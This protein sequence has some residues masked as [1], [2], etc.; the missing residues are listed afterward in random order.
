M[1]LNALNDVM[2][3]EALQEARIRDIELSKGG[4]RGILHGIPVSIKEMYK[5]FGTSSNLGIAA[6][7]D[8]IAM[9]DGELIKVIK[10]MGGIPFVKSN[11][12]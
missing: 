11:V 7:V 8:R 12:P 1:E 5:S 4:K 10:Q 3:Q 2:F 9:E 6:Y